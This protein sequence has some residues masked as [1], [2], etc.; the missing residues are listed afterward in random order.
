VKHQHKKLY[1][2]NLSL[3][4][5]IIIGWAL[6][7]WIQVGKFPDKL[8]VHRANS[9]EKWMEQSTLYPNAEIDLLFLEDDGKYH[10]AHDS[11]DV[12][13]LILDN[14]FQHLRCRDGKLWLDIKNLTN[15]NYL[16]A[17]NELNL[18]CQNYEIDKNRLIIESDNSEALSHF[19]CDGGYF[20]SYYLRAP[21]PTSL[22]SA[23]I[24]KTIKNLQSIVDSKT[25]SALSFPHYWY[26][27]IRTHLNR[28]IS[29]LTWDH[30]T[31][32]FIFHFSFWKRQMLCDSQVKIIL[33]KSKE[34]YHR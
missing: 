21:R 1:I 12:D 22:S 13:K 10:V 24:E 26:D 29:L 31:S 7:S 33:I 5:V 28:N 3:I 9:I 30:H 4:T 20:T 32:E 34:N 2:V 6:Y 14:Y 25:V 27:E 23:E 15:E 11:V 18:L 8:W 16:T 17:L 19:K